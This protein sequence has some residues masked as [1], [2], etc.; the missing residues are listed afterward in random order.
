MAPPTK[1]KPDGKRGRSAGYVVSQDHKDKL[2][3]GRDVARAVNAFLTALETNKPK[4]GRHVSLA[5]MQKRWEAA[6]ETAAQ[7]VGTAKL[8]ATQMAADL[9]ARVHAELNGVDGSV[10]MAELEK[11]FIAAAKEYSQSHGITYNTWRSAGVSADLLRQA[12]IP[13]TAGG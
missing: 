2:A 5:D 6:K 12:G 1:S 11:G 7:S 4:R 10:A 9:E 3:R 13:R 8:L